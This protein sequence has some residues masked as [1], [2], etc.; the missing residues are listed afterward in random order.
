MRRS[1][2]CVATEAKKQNL[3]D[4]YTSSLPLAIREWRI[5]T[6]EHT[7][8]KMFEVKVFVLRRL[9]SVYGDGNY[10]E[11]GVSTAID[12]TIK[13]FGNHFFLFYET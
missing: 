13:H 6:E 1:V 12:L 3:Y 5:D 9:F 8:W 4:S 10:G 2:I 7:Q 11:K